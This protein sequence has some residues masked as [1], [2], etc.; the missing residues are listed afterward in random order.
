[1]S[2]VL[3]NGR[4]LGVAVN[5][6]FTAGNTNPI[7]GGRLWPEAALTWRAMRVAYVA[8]GGD[9]DDFMP[10]GPVSSARPRSAQEFFWANQPPAAAPLYTSNHGW[11]IAVDVKTKKA[12]AWLMRNGAQFG[13]SHDEGARVGEWWH[14]R[15]VGATR[16]Q[17]R[18]A[19]RLL[20]P[21]RFLTRGERRTLAAYR[22]VL[23]RR[24][25]LGGRLSRKDAARRQRLRAEL[26]RS[27]K[28]I[29][30]AAQE[31]GWGKHH[32]RERYELLRRATK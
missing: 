10:A 13:W 23:R 3:V 25:R 2:P 31:D 20:N 9:A 26:I 8:D 15:Y 22:T 4:T 14:Y 24:R 5:G 16:A 7:P 29:W 12:A 30:R 28:G 32:R 17:L 11:A 6:V 18:T 27:R 21:E 1:M 19:R